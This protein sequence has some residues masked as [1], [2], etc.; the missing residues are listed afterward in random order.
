MPRECRCMGSNSNCYICGGRGVIE[1][2]SIAD[3]TKTDWSLLPVKSKPI[4][5]FNDDSTY[6]D[7][8]HTSNGIKKKGIGPLSSRKRKS[9]SAANG[10]VKSK[11]S[12]KTRRV[13]GATVEINGITLGNEGRALSRSK[14]KSSSSSK[15][16]EKT[17]FNSPFADLREKYVQVIEN[18]RK[19]R[20]LDGSRGYHNLRER[21]RFGSYPSFDGDSD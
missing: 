18:N 19:E 9:R 5:S 10:S 2:S 4:S 11:N 21:G 7:E 15:K 17:G 12:P 20:V 16:K 6:G 13:V 3:Q 8:V 14:L 1:S